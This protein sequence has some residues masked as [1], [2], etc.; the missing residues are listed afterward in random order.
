[1]NW[2]HFYKESNGNQWPDLDI[3]KHSLSLDSLNKIEVFVD[4]GCGT[5]SNVRFSID[6][7]PCTLAIDC[8]PSAI[9]K[10]QA[11]YQSKIKIHALETICSDIVKVD[12]ISVLQQYKNKNIVFVDCTTLQHIPPDDQD[13]VIARIA[14]ACKVHSISSS[15]IVNHCSIKVRIQH[16]RHIVLI[17][18]TNVICSISMEL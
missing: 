18:M 8:S 6:T 15:V 7:F 4:I 2:D 10:L 12:W 3:I 17:R 1:M 11:K 13:F 14:S 16:S 9:F 5:G